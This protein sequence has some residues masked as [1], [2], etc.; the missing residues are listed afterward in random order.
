VVWENKSEED[1]MGATRRLVFSHVSQALCRIYQENDPSLGK[2]IRN[3]K[4][5]AKTSACFSLVQCEGQAWICLAT[6]KA[7]A[8]VLP[9]M[10]PEFLEAHLTASLRGE[11][12]AKQVLS[13]LMEIFNAQNLYRKSYPL[14]GLALIIRSAFTQLNRVVEKNNGHDELMPD[15]IEDMIH[16][17]VEAVKSS[18][19]PA[20]VEKRKVDGRTYEAYFGAIRDMLAAEYVQNDG[21]NRSYYDYLHQHLQPLTREEYQHRFRCH[22]EYLAKLTRQE[23]LRQLKKEW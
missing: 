16:A 6:K 11:A 22:F 12:D 5:A 17:N 1:L 4:L 3:L 14:S 23:L 21:C 10:P 8:A 19:R 15:E 2:L 9:M 7:A 20:Y 13:L 18:M